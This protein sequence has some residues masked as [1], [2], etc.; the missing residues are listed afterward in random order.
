MQLKQGEFCIFFLIILLIMILTS[1]ELM[2]IQPLK[3][4][5]INTSN[6]VL[7]EIQIEKENTE[8]EFGVIKNHIQNAR[9][10]AERISIYLS[11]NMDIITSVF[12]KDI[13]EV[14]HKNQQE[15][16]IGSEKFN[17]NIE[18]VVHLHKIEEDL[19]K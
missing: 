12:P 9:K 15:Y 6:M 14:L 10:M 7:K 2:V 16:I 8:K 17:K 18:D 1:I 3:E 13:R 19:D 4:D 11:H 5:L